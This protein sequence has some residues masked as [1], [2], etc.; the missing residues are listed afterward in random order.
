MRVKSEAEMLA[1]G[2]ELGTQFL[3]GKLKMPLDAGVIELIGDVGAGKTTLVRGIARG[4]NIKEPVTSPSFTISKA[5]AFLNNGQPSVLTHYDFYRL[6]DPGL[7]QEDLEETISVPGSLTVV[8][9]GGSVAGLLPENR[10]I[11]RFRLNDD[12]SREV[13]Y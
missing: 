6:D 8:E 4:L 7:M 3:D 9:W 11:V 10:L 12:G 5:Y 2:E 13:N 1:L